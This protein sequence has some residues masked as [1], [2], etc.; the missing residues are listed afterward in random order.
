M[1]P[2]GGDG[3]DPVD[4]VDKDEEDSLLTPTSPAHSGGSSSDGVGGGV[5]GGG[6]PGGGGPDADIWRHFDDSAIFRCPL[7]DISV[8]IDSSTHEVRE[9]IPGDLGEAPAGRLLGR[10]VP[11]GNSFD[12]RCAFCHRVPEDLFLK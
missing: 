6:V 10:C 7:G 2:S 12:L 4:P 9:L 5:P 1:R 11:F 8:T 3:V